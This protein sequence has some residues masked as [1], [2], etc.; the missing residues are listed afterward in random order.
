MLTSNV[1]YLYRHD[2]QSET[3]IAVNAIL[4][5]HN[6]AKEWRGGR[7]QTDPKCNHGPSAVRNGLFVAV[8]QHKVFDRGKL[9][10]LVKIMM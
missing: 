7:R 2:L 6:V 10:T 9:E 8:C 3:S 4:A 5:V 1:D